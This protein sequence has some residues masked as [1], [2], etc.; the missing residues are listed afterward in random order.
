M[1]NV[2]SATA[3]SNYYQ[4]SV[5]AFSGDVAQV[6]SKIGTYPRIKV[7]IIDTAANIEKHLEELKKVVNNVKTITLLDTDSTQIN[8]TAKQLLTPGYSTLLNKISLGGVSNP[9]SLRVS[10]VLANDV[11]KVSANGKVSQ[12][13]VKDLASNIVSKFSQL[14]TGIAKLQGI[15]LSSTAPLRMTFQQY[16]TY[17]ADP[18]RQDVLGK[19]T[20]TFGFDVSGANT[21]QAISM[22][23][24]ERVSSVSIVDH[25]QAIA[26]H[27]DELQALGVKV[28]ALASDDNA[29]MKVNAS[30][31]QADKAVIGKLYK[32]Y[33]FAVFNVDANSAIDLR[34]NKKVITLDIV[35]TA[36]N[37][38]KNLVLLDR[39][40]S[41]VH[42]VRV[43]DTDPLEMT[44]FDFLSHGNVLNKVI[45][46]DQNAT[47]QATTPE[48]AN[49]IYNLNIV[50]ARAVDAQAMINNDHI[51]SIAVADTSSA[52]AVN[53]DDLS[54]NG[55]VTGI[56][57]T[58]NAGVLNIT[59][60]QW[61]NDQGA[62]T[63]LGNEN[64]ML[65]VSGVAAQDALSL[66][67]NANVVSMS[68]SD[69]AENILTNLDDL[70][71]LGKSLTT[72][73]QSDAGQSLQLT[74]SNWTTH[75]GVLSKIVGGYGVDLTGVSATQALNLA[76][77]LRVRTLNV[78]DSGA[79]ISANLDALMGLGTK[80]AA[81]SQSDTGAIQVTGKQFDAYAD[82]SLAKLGA[83]YTLKVISAKASQIQVMAAN[84][85][86]TDMKV[87]DT[88]SNIGSNLSALQS[89]VVAVAAPNIQ[90]DMLGNPSSFILSKTQLDDYADAL[91]KIHGNYTVKATDVLLADAGGVAA[92]AH[93]VSM[94]VKGGA[95]DL[96]DASNLSALRN[97]GTKVNRI[98]Q[99]DAG[100]ALSMSV[101]NWSSNLGV[102]EK[103]KG[104][105]V[106]LTEASVANGL[107]LLTKPHVKSISVTDL[108]SQISG[109]FDKLMALGS[110]LNGITQSDPAMH[111]KLSMPQ[112]NA[113]AAAPT[114]TKVS[115]DYMVDL[116][117]ASA[118]QAQSF[119]DNVKI[120]LIAVTDTASNI[121][122]KLDALAA[123]GKISTL[124]LSDP[125]T[126]VSVTMQQFGDDA[127][128]LA[129]FQGGYG[130]AVTQATTGDLGTVFANAHVVSAEVQGTAD[131]IQST[132]TLSALMQNS[133]RIK[134]LKLTGNDHSMD[135]EY[136]N[137]QKYKA[138]LGKINESFNVS[139]NN[140]SASAALTEAGNT[141][142]NISALNVVDSVSQVAA[143]LNG[144]DN[145]GAKLTSLATT[146]AMPPVLTISVRDYVSEQSVLAKINKTES[147]PA[148]YKLTVTGA[149]MY[150][151]NR[152][153]N[154]LHVQ[155]ISVIDNAETVSNQ[156]DLLNDIHISTVT[157][158]AD[159]S[160]LS[161][162]GSQ[163]SDAVAAGSFSKIKGS[164][165][166][167]I[168][169]AATA[170]AAA[171]EDDGR[172][173]SFSLVASTDIS[174]TVG[175]LLGH[176]KLDHID[177]QANTR[178]ALTATQ[179]A[180][181]QD[182]QSKLR[183]DYA[184]DVSGVSMADLSDVLATSNVGSVRVSGTSEAIATGWDDLSALST[185]MLAGLTVT[186][187][188]T[189][190]A[191][192]YEQ[193]SQS[194]NVL[195]KLPTQSLAL[196]DVAPGQATEAAAQANVATVSI[197]G[198][199][200]EVAAEFDQL[201]T[202]GTQVDD[203]EITDDA[204]MMIT[205][206]QFDAGEATL[207]KINGGNYNPQILA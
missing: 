109:N 78:S 57:Q 135:F 174:A 53:L 184:F 182:T 181:I 199:A 1:I 52:I 31:L 136:S 147:N 134:T 45:N 125:A 176:S 120:G 6:L 171:L 47:E 60:A 116:S 68:V 119:V 155:N 150:A 95:A 203:I 72:I 124:Q 178:L 126:P 42:S 92:N 106:S 80:L 158:T 22:G 84:T 12:F 104:Y 90:V 4:Q 195:A 172:V 36:A 202:L 7:E 151:A 177:L 96:S 139:L 159:S 192:T 43:T 67:A 69:S 46:T 15:Q 175:T 51:Q 186:D 40:G 162:T 77:D 20:G 58:G 19:M 99:T 132:G 157:L 2:Q 149:D 201:V 166:L 128:L 183:G 169:G 113:A 118:T 144:L 196:L 148:V 48:T 204:P 17:G 146:G 137:F 122:G 131:E 38:S 73:T 88:V 108:A 66:S 11:A 32:G 115:G 152:I 35:D 13:S 39:L 141:Q 207:A 114:L 167:N 168:A 105:S 8:I 205:Q 170:Q 41:Q 14:S 75:I 160:Q 107:T 18:A 143:N 30:Q 76:P 145:L 26:D 5:P 140:I 93:V 3:A 185:N 133:S 130:F 71:T 194:A 74:A 117:G 189:P 111:L 173:A 10:D 161:I 98:V 21:T 61:A 180:T 156:I 63:L 100:T 112:W 193:W 164:F 16:T 64:F 197:K 94:D 79:A 27:L 56:S 110:K 153:K 163:Y 188:S 142:F 65:N 97:L 55:K 24:D 200:A 62:L 165:S 198:T 29:I 25:S 82:S 54:A 190:V 81:I 127:A 9:V 206:A 103:I 102:L 89:A 28:K 37:L 154:D 49:N 34:S 179:L 191:I 91:G 138:V 87:A 187:S 44:A 123:N 59:A 33:Q 70:A 23:D 83:D 101:M 86:V 129:K 121:S 50:G 85:H